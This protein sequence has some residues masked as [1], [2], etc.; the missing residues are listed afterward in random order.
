MTYSGIR[1]ENQDEIYCWVYFWEHFAFAGGKR[2]I[3]PEKY[4]AVTLL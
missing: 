4:K 2:S 1:G 3:R